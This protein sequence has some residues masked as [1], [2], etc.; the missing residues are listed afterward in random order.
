MK[1]IDLDKV[2]QI[3]DYVVLTI[4]IIGIWLNIYFKKDFLEYL[5][6][7][8]EAEILI[9]FITRIIVCKI[10]IKRLKKELEKIG[11]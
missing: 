10:N 11:K 4:C 6:I 9:T 7:G 2:L 3:K 8:I 5:L 1:K